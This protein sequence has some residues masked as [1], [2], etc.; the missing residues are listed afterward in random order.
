[1]IAQ[2]RRLHASGDPI[3]RVALR[4]MGRSELVSAAERYCGSFGRAVKLAGIEYTP[5][6]PAWT[7]RRVLDELRR[8]HAEG[9]ELNC[10]LLRKSGHGGLVTA[11]TKYHGNW[12]SAIAKA[13]VPAFKR[14]R[15]KT[16]ADVQSEL[17]GLHARR[18]KLSTSSIRARGL[19]G[20]VDAARRHAGSWNEALA[21]ARLPIVMQYERWT[22]NDVLAGIRRLHAEKVPLNANLVI[23]RGQRKLV[24]AATRHF[25]TWR[26]ACYAAVPGYRPLLTTWTIHRLIRGIKRR[27]R[28]GKS[29]RSTDVQRDEQALTTAARRLGLAWKEAC[30]RA[31]IPAAAYASRAGGLRTRWTEAS[32]RAHLEAAADA[33]TALLVKNFSPGFVTAVYRRWPSWEAAIASAKLT[34]RYKRDLASARAKRLGGAFVSKTRVAKARRNEAH[35]K[36]TRRTK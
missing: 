36:R 17:R 18:V 31:G 29:V 23:A 26:L 5:R 27:H 16:W 35:V 20:L 25:K 10:E 2:L 15:W 14:G 4:E 6:R 9:E 33:G 32:I 7:P 24:K 3:N 28:A 30:R 8:L 11:A 22:R 13:G 21:K 19:A 34:R 12:R 1:M